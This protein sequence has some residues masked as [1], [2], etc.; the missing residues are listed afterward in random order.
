MN[1]FNRKAQLIVSFASQM[2]LRKFRYFVRMHHLLPFGTQHD[3]SNDS[4]LWEST[5]ANVEY[6]FIRT[7]YTT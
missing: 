7:P 1:K 3:W 2:P 6:S 4:E 5:C